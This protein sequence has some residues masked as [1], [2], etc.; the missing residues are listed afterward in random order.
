MIAAA[1][2]IL[3]EMSSSV[4]QPNLDQLRY[5]IG[6]FRRP[7]A[8]TRGDIS[9]AVARIEEFPAELRK[10]VED[11][12]DSQLDTP[13]RPGGWT[14]RQL[15]HHLADS[16]MNSYIRF[17][18]ALTEENPLIKVYD[19]KA[20][21]ELPDART[22]PIENSLLL[23][24]GLHA[25]WVLLLKAMTEAEWKR[26]AQHPQM[27][28]MALDTAA[29]LYAWHGQHHLAHIAKLREQMGW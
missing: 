22:A 17:R 15:V 23:L 2:T 24:G 8:I 6:K 3:E 1:T 5:P 27:G 11:L 9:A 13:Y 19:E 7:E 29:A 12:S 18:W 21:A 28:A 14:V 25:R 26:T 4:T 16:H 20:W 10:I